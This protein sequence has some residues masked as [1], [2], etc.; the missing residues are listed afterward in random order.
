DSVFTF[1]DD[2]L[3]ELANLFPS[4]YIHI[5]GD[6]ADKTRWIACPKCQKRVKDEGLK[7]EKELQSYFIKRV[8]KIVISKGKKMIGWDEILEGGLAP[9]ATV[10]SWRGIEGGIAAARQGH[11]VIMTPTSYCYFDYCQGESG[12]EPT[13]IGGYLPLKKVYSYEPLPKELSSAEQ[14]HILGAQAN[15]WTEYIP[16][17]SHVEYMAIPRMLALSEVVWSPQKSRNWSDF[18]KRLD[19]QFKRLDVMKVNYAKGS[20]KVDIS[21]FFDKKVKTLKLKLETELS[22]PV[23]RYTLNGNDPKND[24]PQ[25]TGPVDITKNCYVKAAVFVDGKIHG[26]I[27]ERTIVYHHAIGKKIE[28]HKPYSYRFTGGGDEAVVD[29]IRA[30]SDLH[31]GNWQG[32]LGNDMELIIDLGKE[33]PIH[34]INSTFLQ[35]ADAWVF[36][37]EQVTYSLS[38]DKKRFHSIHEVL[39]DVK[40]KTDKPLIKMFTDIFPGTSARYIKVEAKNVGICPDWHEGKGEKCWMF[41]DEISVF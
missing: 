22:S 40:Q 5:G 25:Y 26:D 14:K 16:I 4:K 21:T 24:S 10:M 31:D 18:R 20:T 29:G 19:N 17:P 28:Y 41:V 11:D 37:P 2:V 39:N 30:T 34:S 6:E 8:E 15:I 27:A 12:Y 35:N 23:I 7:N 33:Q 32:Y 9:E 1:I 38:S 36:F 13:S 3:T